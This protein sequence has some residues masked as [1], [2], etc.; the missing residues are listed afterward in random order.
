[1]DS[2]PTDSRPTDNRPTDNRPTDSHMEACRHSHTG[3]DTAIPCTGTA[4]DVDE[5]D[6]RREGEE[7]ATAIV[8]HTAVVKPTHMTATIRT[9]T[10]GGEGAG[11]GAG[12]EIG[13]GAEGGVEDTVMTEATGPKAVA[14][15]MQILEIFARE[16]QGGLPRK[17]QAGQEET[18]A[19][20]QVV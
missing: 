12:I 3:L 8:T 17:S 1:M 10:V 14:L 9:T 18:E 11:N 7:T 16:R 2:R 13:G 5:T 15:R 4:L 20:V 6:I 19:R